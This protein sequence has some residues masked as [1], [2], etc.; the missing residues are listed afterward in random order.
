[1]PFCGRCGNL[2]GRN[3]GSMPVVTT[4]TKQKSDN[5]AIS[6]VLKTARCARLLTQCKLGNTTRIAANITR[7]TFMHP[8]RKTALTIGTLVGLVSIGTTI[9]QTTNPTPTATI[10]AGQAHII[11]A[12]KLIVKDA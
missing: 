5:P 10:P 1:M 11:G 3:T 8:L 6:A 2:T 7:G 12:A 4:V 9:A